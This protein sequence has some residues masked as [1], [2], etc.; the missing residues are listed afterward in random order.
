MLAMVG[1]FALANTVT[2]LGTTYGQSY[3]QG[4]VG[5][6]TGLAM[7][8]PTLALISGTGA[9]A[10]TDP[11]NFATLTTTITGCINSCTA[12]HPTEEAKLTYTCTGATYTFSVTVTVIGT[13]FSG[14]SGTAHFA[15]SSS[16]SSGTL[17]T[18]LFDGD[19]GA[20]G[21]QV[22]TS[23]TIVANSP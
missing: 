19:L 9:S 14:V 13:G 22:V 6:V 17:V 11:T 23:V 18:I 12:G 3:T 10:F 20:A 7:G 16:C 4:N 8:T 1:G 5:S 21:S 2:V 15:D